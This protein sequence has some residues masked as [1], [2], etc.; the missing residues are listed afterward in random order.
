MQ[1][2]A[3][4]NPANYRPISLLHTAYTIM[5]KLLTRRLEVGLEGKLRDTQFGFRRG[6]SA[7]EPLFSIRRL[8]DLVHAKKNQALHLSFLDWSK[9]VDKVDAKCIPL[10]LRRFGVGERW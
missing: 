5:G 4:T 2:R 9:A 10:V 1:E 8:Q 7:A 6:R 3:A